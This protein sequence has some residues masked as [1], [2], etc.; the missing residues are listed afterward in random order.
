M[1]KDRTN[2]FETVGALILLAVFIAL[3]VVVYNLITSVA[4][5]EEVWTMCQPDSYLTVREHP[6]KNS[7]EIGQLY[8]G[9]KADTD[10]KK[11]NGYLHIVDA[12]TESGDGWVCARYLVEDEPV[13]VC[14]EGTITG[15]GRVAVRREPGGKRIRWMKPG[16]T[17]MIFAWSAEWCVTSKGFID[18]DYLEGE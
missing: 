17:V 1:K 4:V 9:D 14:E 10:G 12:S 8:L 13:L 11:K 3:V 16:D 7:A 18:S 2:L 15:R 5:G 6:N